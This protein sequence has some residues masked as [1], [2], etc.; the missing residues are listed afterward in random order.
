[1]IT[2]L[3]KQPAEKSKNPPFVEYRQPNACDVSEVL[4][5]LVQPLGRTAKEKYEGSCKTATKAV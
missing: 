5:R 3:P 4:W 2:K 1:M